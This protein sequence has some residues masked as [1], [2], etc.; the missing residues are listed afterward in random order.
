MSTAFVTD[1]GGLRPIS[2]EAGRAGDEGDVERDW[3]AAFTADTRGSWWWSSS[4]VEGA[5]A[6]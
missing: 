4:N 5:A 3:K 1:K 6:W 2:V